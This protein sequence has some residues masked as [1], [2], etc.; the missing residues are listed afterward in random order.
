MNNWK[1]DCAPNWARPSA[2]VTD[3]RSVSDRA[4]PVRTAAAACATI[5]RLPRTARGFRPRRG[6][7]R[8]RAPPSRSPISSMSSTPKASLLCSP[9]YA[10]HSTPMSIEHRHADRPLRPSPEAA[11]TTTTSARAH[12]RSPTS[13]PAPSTTPLAYA[14]GSPAPAPVCMS[15][16][17]EASLVSLLLHR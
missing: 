10:P 15:R 1:N 14:S 4:T 7:P 11:F 8:P 17:H 2:T 9:L 13:E 5:F 16:R 6:F 3:S 12:R